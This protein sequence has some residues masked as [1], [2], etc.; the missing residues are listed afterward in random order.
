M[1]D[2]VA[3]CISSLTKGKRGH[4][5]KQEQNY[6]SGFQLVMENLGCGIQ[7]LDRSG[8]TASGNTPSPLP[9][10]GLP[11]L[12]EQSPEHNSNAKEMQSGVLDIHTEPGFRESPIT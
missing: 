2:F 11:T 8:K 6:R 7:H 9:T 5:N 12:R 1:I 3:C 10:L 4:I